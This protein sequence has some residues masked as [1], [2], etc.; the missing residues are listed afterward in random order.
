MAELGHKLSAI[1]LSFHIYADDVL[2]YNEID[3][4]RSQISFS[5]LQEGLDLTAGW[6]QRNR[7]QLNASKTSLHIFRSARAKL[8]DFCCS[9]LY[10]NG[11]ALQIAPGGLKWLGVEVDEK[12]TLDKFIADK[13]KSAYNEIRMIRFVGEALD[14]STRTL[15]VNALVVSRLLY[16]D[17]LLAMVPENRMLKIQRVWN[18]AT[19]TITGG[20]KYDH[21]TP[22]MNEL[23][24]ISARR[25]AQLKIAKLVFLSLHGRA[26]Q[27]LKAEQQVPTRNLR[28]VADGAVLLQI[29]VPRGQMESGRWEVVSASVWN[30]LPSSLRVIGKWTL[31]HFLNGVIEQTSETQ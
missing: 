21:V 28:S 1:G 16:C 15:L 19:K 7:L 14:K 22:I 2:L 25:R 8:G 23:H 29:V 20:R 5:K 4:Q 17:S 30:A 12:L 3:M 9:A 27:Y 31:N 26:P 11:E 13:C 10:L 18:C 6:M 24:W